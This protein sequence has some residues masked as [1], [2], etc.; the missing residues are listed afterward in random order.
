MSGHT[1]GPWRVAVEA[2]N[3]SSVSVQAGKKTRVCAVRY[4]WRRPGAYEKALADAHLISAA[5]DL[6]EALAK[7][8]ILLRALAGPDDVMAQAVIG[9]NLKAIAKATGS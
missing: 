9:E 1:P 7:S 4:N 3:Q 2:N 8:H 6:L 5:A